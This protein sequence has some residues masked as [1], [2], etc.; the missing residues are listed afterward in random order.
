M[1]LKMGFSNPHFR[2]AKSWIW[3]IHRQKCKN[4]ALPLKPPTQSCKIMTLTFCLCPKH[5][6]S[7]IRD[8]RFV[9][10]EFFCKPRTHKCNRW[11]SKCDFEHWTPPTIR[12]FRMSLF[13]ALFLVR[14]KSDMGFVAFSVLSKKSDIP[15]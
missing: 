1:E 6:I 11:L 14:Q 2:D 15:W 9:S 12:R 13:V 5:K 4:M 10:L 7:S 8:C 3:K